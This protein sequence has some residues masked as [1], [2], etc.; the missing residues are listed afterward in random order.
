MKTTTIVA[1]GLLT[2]FALA[3]PVTADDAEAPKDTAE[4]CE[5]AW[6]DVHGKPH[7]D[8][9]CIGPVLDSSP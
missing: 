6:I 2:A 1:L 9:D 8:A 4:T 7:V 3:G 5:P